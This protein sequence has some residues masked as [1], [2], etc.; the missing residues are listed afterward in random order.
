MKAALQLE[1]VAYEKNITLET[2]IPEQI[3]LRANEKYLQRVAASLM[4][5]AIKY[6]PSGGRVW[7]QLKA[8]KRKVRLE[9]RNQGSVIPEE[10]LPHIFERFYRCD[11]NRHGGTG[12]HGLG[13][14]ITKQ[15][16][17]RLDGSISVESGSGTVFIV[18]FDS[19]N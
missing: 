18:E 19:R 12:G 8:T 1:S 10:D 4:E 2:E 3:M 5:N 7:I 13:L 16:V 9:V 17:E 15:M 14:S 11:K 6:E